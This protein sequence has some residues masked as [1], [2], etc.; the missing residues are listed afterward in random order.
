M[1]ACCVEILKWT[2]DSGG[3]R[4]AFYT[5]QHEP[6]PPKPM[7]CGLHPCGSD[8]LR[9]P[10]TY[11]SSVCNPNAFEFAPSSFHLIPLPTAI[12]QVQ[13]NASGDVHKLA[14]TIRGNQVRLSSD[15]WAAPRK[16]R[17]RNRRV[18][19]G[20]AGMWAECFVN[21]MRSLIFARRCTCWC[22]A[23]QLGRATLVEH[24][25]RIDIAVGECLP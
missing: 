25:S 19:C 16:P 21:P 8:K 20:E 4:G 2:E 9:I 3:R 10:A 13:D 15:T 1:A 17:P 12:Q 7:R 22:F 14:V 24:H 6:S 11:D 23:S 18:Y 5:A